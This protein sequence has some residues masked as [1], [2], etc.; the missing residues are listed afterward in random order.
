MVQDWDLAAMYF[1]LFVLLPRSAA[2]SCPQPR[3][4]HFPQRST[5]GK[6]TFGLIM[7]LYWAV[8]MA[9]GRLQDTK[10]PFSV[11]IGS[12]ADGMF[13]INM[14]TNAM[15]SAGLSLTWPYA[16]ISFPVLLGAIRQNVSLCT[17]TVAN[18]LFVLTFLI[19]FLSCRLL[20]FVIFSVTL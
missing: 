15:H 5:N 16:A 9:P 13:A 1:T 19:Q 7:R 11:D 20:H 4:L 14:N 18:V 12:M 10:W 2:W 6:Q 17:K 8:W 3:A